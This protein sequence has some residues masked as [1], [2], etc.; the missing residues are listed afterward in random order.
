MTSSNNILISD[1]DQRFSAS[2]NEHQP[3]TND[4]QK[5][6]VELYDAWLKEPATKAGL[7]SCA[8][9]AIGILH[10]DMTLRV[11]RSHDL[12]A[13][14]FAAWREAWRDRLGTA[15]QEEFFRQFPSIASHL[16]EDTIKHVV[17]E[18]VWP[19]IE[20]ELMAFAL[21]G[22]ART[23]VRQHMGDLTTIGQPSLIRGQWVIPLGI[24]DDGSELGQIVLDCEGNILEKRSSSRKDILAKING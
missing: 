11:P 1:S 16:S 17:V 21:Q 12:R 13:N 10:N 6:R 23:W 7:Q 18:F 22:L 24:Q 15:M 14:K 5:S 19:Q 3:L 8:D 20:D 4:M 2:K 9:F